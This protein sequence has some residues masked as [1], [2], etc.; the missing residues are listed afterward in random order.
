[1][2]KKDMPQIDD[3]SSSENNFEN[4]EEVVESIS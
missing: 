1:L 4:S 3:E 2:I